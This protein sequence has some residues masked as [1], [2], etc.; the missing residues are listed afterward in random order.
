VKVASLIYPFGWKPM[1]PI[2]LIHAEHLARVARLL[3]ANGVPAE[4]YLER[5]RLWP[6]LLEHPTGF[7]VGHSI[8]ALLDEAER[9]EALGEFWLDIARI[10]NWRRAGW[11]PPLAHAATLGDAIR[12]MCRSYVRQIPMMELGLALDGEVAWFWRRRVC[13]VHDWRGNQQTE[14]YTLSFMLEVVRAAAGPKWLPECVQV[15]CSPSGWP[16]AT[17]RLPGVRFEYDRPML[18]LAIPVPLLALPIAIQPLAPPGAECASP[19]PDFQGSLRQVLEPCLE[20][21]LPDQ[22]TA[23]EMLWTTPRTLRRRLAQE[24][25]AWRTV[26]DD[27]KFARAVDRLR[28]GRASMRE[29]AEELG[30]AAAAHFTRFFRRRAGVSPSAYRAE[31]ARA[32]TLARPT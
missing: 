28:E 17:K 16:A 3:D 11:V 22:K 4:R 29:I 27:V 21:G 2:P 20:D 10:S 13:D 19:A 18:A 26:V 23:A 8:W 6:G 5:A 31:V 9:G 15:Q 32:R 30:Y 7:V 12:V 25:T 24:D 14:Q 1:Q